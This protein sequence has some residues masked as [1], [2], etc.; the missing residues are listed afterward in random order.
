[1]VAAPAN[2]ELESFL[3]QF[4]RGVEARDPLNKL[5]RWLGYIQ[6]RLIA[7]ELTDVET[8]RNWSRPLFQ[9]LDFPE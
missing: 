7:E 5:N 6:G 9:P 1:M 8:E 3:D 4:K 2:F